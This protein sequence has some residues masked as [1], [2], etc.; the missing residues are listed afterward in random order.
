MSSYPP[1]AVHPV[2]RAR[3]GL[4]DAAR[5]ILNRRVYAVLGTENDDG[6]VHL[7]PV[8]FLFD[9]ERG[10]ILVETA[11]ATRKARNIAARPRA[12]LL[13]QTPEAAWV[14]GSGPATLVR[15]A[16]GT[17]LSDSIRAKYLTDQGLKDCGSVLAELDDVTIVLTPSRWLEWDM[18]ALLQTL[19]AR[20][21]NLDDTELWFQAD[22]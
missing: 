21:A 5:R 8:L 7:V 12:S 10:H 16:E 22:Q 14:C 20:G 6:S 11:A 15:G 13:V 17:R 4:T 9:Q 18:N 3:H 1:T 19:A 2:Y